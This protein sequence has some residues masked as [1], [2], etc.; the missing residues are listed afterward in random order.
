MMILFFF[1]DCNRLLVVANGIAAGYSLIQGLRCGLSMIKG[2]VLF[3][4][5]LAW[6]I[7]SGD[8]VVITI[9][10]ILLLSVYICF[11]LAV[12]QSHHPCDFYRGHVR[13]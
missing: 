2:S 8:Q 7:F 9:T 1:L 10:T 13:I 6:A 12:Q 3:N 4:K 5:P 11:T